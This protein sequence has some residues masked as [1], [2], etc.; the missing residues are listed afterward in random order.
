MITRGRATVEIVVTAQPDRD[1]LMRAMRHVRSTT[2]SRV[3]LLCVGYV[4]AGAVLLLFPYPF[5]KLLG[6]MLLFVAV[7]TQVA[8][9]FAYREALR[10]NLLIRAV[11]RTVTLTDCGFEVAFRFGATR[12]DWP[13]VISVDI[14]PGLLIIRVTD[15]RFFEVPTNGLTSAEFG[16]ITAVLSRVQWERKSMAA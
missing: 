4:V 6:L 10:R 2:V 9:G 13:G 8:Q 1:A 7:V 12:L 14:I 15:R 16:E 11:P 5:V 3:R